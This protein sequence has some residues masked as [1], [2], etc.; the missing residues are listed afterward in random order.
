MHTF[1]AL[2]TW[3]DLAAALAAGRPDDAEIAKPWIGGNAFVAWFAGASD[4]LGAV[5]A[6]WSRAHDRRR[7]RVWLPDYFCNSATAPMRAVGIEPTFYP[8]GTSLA[9]DWQACRAMAAENAPPD[10]FLL[11]HYFGAAGAGAPAAAFCRETGALLI[12]DAAHVLAPADGIGNFGDFT[13]YSQHKTMVV[14]DGALLLAR[15]PARL[16]GGDGL[17]AVFDGWPSASPWAWMIK[18]ALQKAAPGAALAQ[19]VRSLPGFEVDQVPAAT[20]RQHCAS[21]A[22]RAMI[23][24]AGRRIREI[25]QCKKARAMAWRSVL[26]AS[27]GERPLFTPSAEGEAPYRFVLQC[28]ERAAAIARFDALR[29][30]GVAVETWPDLAPEVTAKPDRHG[31]AIEFRST[32]LFLP[33]HGTGFER[34]PDI[35]AAM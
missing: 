1:A 4:A 26:A 28:P 14:P 24:R 2:P 20:V 25:A 27:T 8:I 33:V 32:L 6:W 35:V 10:L 23:A 21:T 31:T 15:D 13:L 12:E 5:T 18:R 11:V 22:G 29:Q 7:P 16:P 19:R 9:P 3:T 17:A 30:Q 34:L